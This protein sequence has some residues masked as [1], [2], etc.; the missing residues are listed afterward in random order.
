MLEL[1]VVE[2]LV[3]GVWTCFVA[4][5]AWFFSSAKKRE[6]E[7]A[8]V[9]ERKRKKQEI[10]SRRVSAPEQ[11]RKSIPKPPKRPKTIRPC[12]RSRSSFANGLAVGF[13]LTFLANFIILW[14][15]IFYTSQLSAG[16]SYEKM[17]VVF[18][19]PM[20]FILATGMVLLTTGIVRWRKL[21][22]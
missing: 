10:I 17:I 5:G 21:R 7:Q 18:I 20:L 14:I 16:I 22:F 11:V 6:R 9:Q 8:E 1:L 4:Y 19:Y 15:S 13:G 2:L 12:G 3:V